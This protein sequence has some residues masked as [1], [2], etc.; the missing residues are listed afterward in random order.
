MLARA[1][2]LFQA[3]SFTFGN[4]DWAWDAVSEL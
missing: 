4:S 3:L 1:T 2:P